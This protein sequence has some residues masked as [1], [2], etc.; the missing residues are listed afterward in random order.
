MSKNKLS[1]KYAILMKEDV[2]NVNLFFAMRIFSGK[3]SQF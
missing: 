3:M 1:R 2:D